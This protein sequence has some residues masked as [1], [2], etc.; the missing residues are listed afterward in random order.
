[1]LLCYFKADLGESHET[2]NSECTSKILRKSKQNGVILPNAMKEEQEK[3][4]ACKY[5]IKSLPA[6]ATNEVI[7]DKK[8]LPDQ[9]S[10]LELQLS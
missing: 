5:T 8:H 9:T 2:T 4:S 1:M 7:E 6:A 10:V 3:M